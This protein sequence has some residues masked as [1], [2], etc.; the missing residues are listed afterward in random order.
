MIYLAL[1]YITILHFLQ[2]L[3]LITESN[4]TKNIS[5]SF[6][7]AKYQTAVFVKLTIYKQS[8]TMINIYY[9]V[10]KKKKLCCHNTQNGMCR[11]GAMEL[12]TL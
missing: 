12:Y 5:Q 7:H 11:T 8:L 3:T 1:S 4:Y 10:K 9:A 2:C 6:V